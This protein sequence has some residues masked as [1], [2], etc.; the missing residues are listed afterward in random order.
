MFLQTH[1]LLQVRS[2]LMGSKRLSK[3]QTKG[4]KKENILQS[5]NFCDVFVLSGVLDWTQLLSNQKILPWGN[6]DQPIC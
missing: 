2:N 5:V 4:M 6:T 3:C 1:I